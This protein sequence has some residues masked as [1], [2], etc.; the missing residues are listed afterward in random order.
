MKFSIRDL[1]LVTVIVALV[2]GWGVDHWRQA[3]RYNRLEFTVKHFS[4]IQW[5]SR[6]EV[7]VSDEYPNPPRP[8]SSAPAPNPPKP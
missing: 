3:E 5:D 4:V 8:K 2:L 1:L 6:G 7:M